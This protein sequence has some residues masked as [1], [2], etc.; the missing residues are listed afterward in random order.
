MNFLKELY[1]EFNFKAVQRV[2]TLAEQV[3]AD[4]FFLGEFREEFL[5][6]VRY[7]IGALPSS[8]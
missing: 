5:D 4:D 2:L 1:V 7:L 3:V 8:N 6:D